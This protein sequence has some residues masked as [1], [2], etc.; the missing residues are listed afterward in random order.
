MNGDLLR[1]AEAEYDALL[2]I[3]GHIPDQQSLSERRLRLI[4]LKAWRQ[5]HAASA[6]LMPGIER[7]LRMLQPGEHVFVMDERRFQEMERI[8]DQPLIVVHPGTGKARYVS[9]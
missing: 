3:D 2:T 5:G 4:I 1:Q 6:L 8:D 9:E 7:A